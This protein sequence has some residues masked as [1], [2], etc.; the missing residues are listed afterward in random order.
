MNRRDTLKAIGLTALSAGTL[1]EACNP[2]PAPAPAAAATPT[3]VPGREPF[4]VERDK[5]LQAE[6]F[7]TDAE[8]ATIT[9]L[10]D[11]I[12]P[13]DD[14]SGSASEAGVPAYI[15]FVSKDEPDTQVPLRGGLRWL[16]LQCLER[17]GQA[18][19]G[20]THDQQIQ[21]IDQIAYPG[22]ADPAM[23]QGVAF[24]SRLRDLTASGFY[25]S[26]MGVKDLGY[27]GNRPGTWTGVPPE[28]LK[29]YGLEGV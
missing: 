20:C 25:T 17:Y 2:K 24:F 16:D 26:E 7:F 29:Q 1:L 11:I 18:F 27:V 22:K 9:V 23:Q 13:K 4:E 15:E 12:I 14:H 6:K 5:R 28:V 19:T 3:D 21:L 8:L 10:V